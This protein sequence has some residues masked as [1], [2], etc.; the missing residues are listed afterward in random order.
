MKHKIIETLEQ[1]FSTADTEKALTLKCEAASR[2]DDHLAENG[3]KQPTIAE[4][5]QDIFD[6]TN[7]ELPSDMNVV[8]LQDLINQRA[9]TLADMLGIELEDVWV[10]K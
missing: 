9:V 6:L 10:V 5:V 4:L 3:I 8:D 2:L 1:A 7:S